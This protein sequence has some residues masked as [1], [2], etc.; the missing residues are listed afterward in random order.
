[1]VVMVLW[2]GLWLGG[3]VWFV[4]ALQDPHTLGGVVP[5]LHSSQCGFA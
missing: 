1:V 4:V 3:L 2:A 5:M